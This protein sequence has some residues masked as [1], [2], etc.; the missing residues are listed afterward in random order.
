MR[1]VL[2]QVS[3]SHAYRKEAQSKKEEGKCL[4]L[5]G[6]Q[7]LGYLD[8]WAAPLSFQPHESLSRSL[9][10]IPILQEKKLRF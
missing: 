2:G 8:R 9:T 6:R 7:A 10:V 4:G 1:E 3:G 5:L